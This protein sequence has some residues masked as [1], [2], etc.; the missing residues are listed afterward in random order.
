MTVETD[1]PVKNNKLGKRSQLSIKADILLIYILVNN[2]LKTQ[3]SF[4]TV[5]LQAKYYLRYD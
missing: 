5:T 1:R 3:N 2:R 4:R